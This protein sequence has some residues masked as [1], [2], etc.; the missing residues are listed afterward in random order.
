M[1][2]PP[3]VTCYQRSKVRF[4]QPCVHPRHSCR[5]IAANLASSETYKHGTHQLQV[6]CLIVPVQHETWTS[7]EI[8]KIV[9]CTC[10]G[11]AGNVFPAAD[12]KGNRLL[13]IPVCIT[14]RGVMHVGIANNRWWGKTLPAFPAHA[15]PTILR[16]LQEVHD[17]NTCNLP[18]L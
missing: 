9:G 11:N 8:R 3:K 13:A 2:S 10:A 17:L 7:Y 18:L 1:D 5:W 6:F 14:A 15:Q 12:F 4:H 16:I